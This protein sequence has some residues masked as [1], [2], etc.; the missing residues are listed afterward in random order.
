M[1]SPAACLFDLDGVL[2]D[3]EPLQARAWKEAAT[4]FGC[5]LDASQLRSLRGR[6]RPDCAE[7]V[8]LW[9]QSGTGAS[10]GSEALLAV[11]QPL[12]DQLL[13]GARPMPG[14]EA[15]VLNCVAQGI[16]MA[17]ATSSSRKAVQRKAA[18]HSWL[19]LI[20]VRVYGD[21]PALRGGKPSPDPF[22]LAA[23]RIGAARVLD[24]RQ[25]NEFASGHVPAADHIELGAL[26]GRADTLPPGPT[27]LMC[28]HGER[29]MSAASLL[30]RAGHR[31]IAVL[32][33]GPQDWSEAT[34]RPVEI[35]S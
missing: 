34:G 24:I 11:R 19:D 22:L 23:E 5:D 9:I 33:G 15:L 16:P 14:A 20:K 8:C 27:V 17:L 13:P 10:P 7:Q 32:G 31:D 30:A 35:A 6:R 18:P 12:A 21:D 29:A 2:L 3:T 26:P 1:G 28:G 4:H 25:D